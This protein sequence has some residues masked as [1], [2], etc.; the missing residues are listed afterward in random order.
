MKNVT[1]KNELPPKYE[2]WSDLYNDLPENLLSDPSRLIVVNFL[3]EAHYSTPWVSAQVDY[4]LDRDFVKARVFDEMQQNLAIDKKWIRQ[5]ERILLIGD[6]PFK[7]SMPIDE[8]QSQ[9]TKIYNLASLK[10]N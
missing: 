1:Y 9:I 8:S 6:H 5:V 2:S 10:K 3:Q 7:Y 4:I